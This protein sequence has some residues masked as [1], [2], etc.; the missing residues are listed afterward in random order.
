[1]V[2]GRLS[3]HTEGVDIDRSSSRKPWRRA[4]MAA[5]VA[6]GVSVLSGGLYSV[7]LVLS[8]TSLVDPSPSDLYHA[9]I[10][11]NLLLLMALPALI[12]IIGVVFGRPSLWGPSPPMS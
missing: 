2:R 7:S 6:A 3:V 5:G 12:L 4:A 8:R 11:R 1:M 10:G 9:E